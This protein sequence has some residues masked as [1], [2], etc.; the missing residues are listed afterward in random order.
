MALVMKY[1]EKAIFLHSGPIPFAMNA[2][3]GRCL[4][5]LTA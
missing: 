2:D 1:H 4:E 5:A 3:T